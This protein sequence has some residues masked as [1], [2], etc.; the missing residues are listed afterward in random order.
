MD[1]M[2]S[3]TEVLAR[4][5]IDADSEDFEG[6]QLG[7]VAVR[8]LLKHVAALESD[9]WRQLCRIHSNRADALSRERDELREQAAFVEQHLGVISGVLGSPEPLQIDDIAARLHLLI[10]ERNALA[11]RLAEIEAQPPSMYVLRST[12]GSVRPAVVTRT[13]LLSCAQAD[14]VDA[15]EDHLDPLFARPA[16][17]AAQERAEPAAKPCRCGPDGCSD[18]VSCPRGER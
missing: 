12:A 1:D 17:A 15:G 11:A 18:R 8:K 4:L 5:R 3:A 14:R 6:A 2:M 13:S 7:P 9:R 16:P 10:A